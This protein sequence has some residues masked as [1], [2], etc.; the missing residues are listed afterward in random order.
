MAPS[1]TV[2]PARI[3]NASEIPPAH[4][5]HLNP[6]ARGW[7]DVYCG[8]LPGDIDAPPAANELL[9]RGPDTGGLSNADYV[10]S[11]ISA[12]FDK[13]L[14]SLDDPS[15]KDVKALVFVSGSRAGAYGAFHFPN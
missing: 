4:A 12:L 11:R 15:G 2:D 7:V 1:Q 14:P 6:S 8:T 13:K 5:K 3:S 9:S 10:Y